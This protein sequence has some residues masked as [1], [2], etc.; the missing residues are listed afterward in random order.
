MYVKHYIK[1]IEKVVLHHV[2]VTHPLSY[3]KDLYGYT[4]FALQI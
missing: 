2:E 3:L 1:N 4:K